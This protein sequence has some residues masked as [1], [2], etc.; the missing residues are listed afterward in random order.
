MCKLEHHQGS[1]SS[2]LS[3]CLLSFVYFL[4]VAPSIA[5]SVSPAT[6]NPQTS[7]SLIVSTNDGLVSVKATEASLKDVIDRI[8][9][10]HIAEEPVIYIDEAW[11]TRAKSYSGKSNPNRF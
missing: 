11:S 3:V 1:F 6:A 2:L 10:V 9:E 7:K 5:E 8:F 4:W